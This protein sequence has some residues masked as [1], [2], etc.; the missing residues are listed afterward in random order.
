MPAAST[1]PSSVALPPR[2]RIAK[3][4]ARVDIA[5]PSALTVWAVK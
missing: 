1:T 4:T 3:V 5:L 2:P